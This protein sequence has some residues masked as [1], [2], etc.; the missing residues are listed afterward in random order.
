MTRQDF[1]QKLDPHL[2][3]AGLARVHPDTTD[4]SARAAGAAL[5]GLPHAEQIWASAVQ[6]VV[7]V[8]GERIPGVELARR[9]QL[10]DQ[11]A[12]SLSV[13]ARGRVQ[14]L[15]L[16][17]YE[18]PVPAEERAFVLEKG[19]VA[20]LF[21]RGRVGTWVVSLSERKIYASKL[22]GLPAE[23]SADQLGALL[24]LLGTGAAAPVTPPQKPGHA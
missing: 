5:A 3:A 23:L 24:P 1:L 4:P 22:R 9:A 6:I 12:R 20:P 11:R 19:R 17:L 7:V 2:S 13:R 16:A 15:Q 10:L 18:R 14:V 21:G 8:F